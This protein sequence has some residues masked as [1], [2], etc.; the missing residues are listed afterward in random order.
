MNSGILD[1][2]IEI[3]SIF[4]R[5]KDNKDGDGNPLIYAL[6]DEN[7]WHFK[8]EEDKKA[9]KRQIIKITKNLSLGIHLISQ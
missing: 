1:P 4:K 5:N 6:K 3:W 7:Q 9:I 2:E 8:S